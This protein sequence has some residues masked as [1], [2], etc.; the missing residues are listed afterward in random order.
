MPIGMLDGIGNPFDWSLLAGLGQGQPGALFPDAPA[1][2]ADAAY[3]VPSYADVVRGLEAVRDYVAPPPPTSWRTFPRDALMAL[4]ALPAR[5]LRPSARVTVEPHYMEGRKEHGLRFWPEGSKPGSSGLN[6]SLQGEVR[7]SFLY[8]ESARGQGLGRSMYEAAV[9][10]FGRR[11]MPLVSDAGVSAKA[12]RVYESLRHGGG[13]RVTRNPN[14]A[15][16]SYGGWSSSAG[17]VFTVEQ[18]A[19]TPAVP[20]PPPWLDW[21]VPFD[22]QIFR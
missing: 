21:G 9:D 11:G 4:S 16:D 5:S 8:P 19:R 18:A 22:Q 1:S 10:Y 17:P 14:A 7:N 12:A 13:Y 3:Q 6:T 15:Q 2:R 20:I